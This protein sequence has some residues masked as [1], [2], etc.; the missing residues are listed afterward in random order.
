M[1]ASLSPQQLQEG[2]HQQQWQ[3]PPQQLQ[4]EQWQQPQ[5]QLLQEGQNH[6]QHWEQQWQQQPQEQPLQAGQQQ[7]PLRLS[8]T[9]TKDTFLFRGTTSSVRNSSGSYPSGKIDLEPLAEQFPDER[10]FLA[11]LWLA[12]A[13]RD[14][15]G[16]PRRL[17][18]NFL[19]CRAGMLIFVFSCTVPYNFI[20]LPPKMGGTLASTLTP[21]GIG[22]ST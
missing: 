16:N 12:A 17:H 22:R 11:E 1:E 5:Q 20:L 3:Q 18:A 19:S 10:G 13:A 8:V 9:L 21:P 14:P 15:E 7:V 4:E 2:Q 6:Q